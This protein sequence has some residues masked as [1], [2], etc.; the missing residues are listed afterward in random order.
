MSLSLWDLTGL[1]PKN[2]Q[3]WLL[4]NWANQ[5][6]ERDVLEQAAC[7]ISEMLIQCNTSSLSVHIC[8]SNR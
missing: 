7:S 1:L 2:G 8:I 3:K 4:N 6:I 5:Q